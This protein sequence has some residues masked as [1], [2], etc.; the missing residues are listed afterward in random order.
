MHNNHFSSP[1]AT[2]LDAPAE[3]RDGITAMRD[4]ASNARRDSPLFNSY[5]QIIDA[6]K[7]FLNALAGATIDEE[8]ATRLAQD[9]EQ[10][11]QLLGNQQVPD[12]ERLWGHWPQRDDR[13]QALVPTVYDEVVLENSNQAPN[14]TQTQQ[15]DVFIM[16]GKVTLGRFWT[17]MN[18]A[19]HGGAVTLLFDEFLGNV[20]TRAKL[21][22]SR[23]AYLNTDFR[24]ITPV[25]KELTIKGQV[26]RVEGR[27]QFLS[28]QLFDG[29]KLCAE[30]EGLWVAL[31][32][33]QL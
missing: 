2:N 18:N 32:P 13:G 11:T 23:T 7:P 19:V 28:G 16:E 22:T 6:L 33:G 9:L 8:Q 4:L 1:T 21:P 24:S 14:G 5:G 12:P 29:Q 31:K 25:D 30:A 26:T 17:G 27:K 15:N 10:W 20:S 3:L